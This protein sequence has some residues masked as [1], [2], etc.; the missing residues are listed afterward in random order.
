MKLSNITILIIAVSL[1]IAIFVWA[2]LIAYYDSEPTRENLVKQV[3]RQADIHGGFAV[4]E[5]ETTGFNTVPEQTDIRPC[6]TASG[7]WIC[8]RDDVVACPPDIPFHTWIE[9][10]GKR[11][12]CL[13]HTAKAYSHRFDISF[14][15]DL[16]S[17][18]NWGNPI[19]TIKIIT[20]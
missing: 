12:E 6:E 8:G 17:A 13:D 20:N 10:D 1:F 11:Y 18:I 5:A 2:Y 3:N 14:D 19:K 15:K 16:E 7:D 4:V 9:I